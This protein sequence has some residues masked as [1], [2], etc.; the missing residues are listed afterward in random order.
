MS[1]DRIKLLHISTSLAT[2]GAQMMLYKLLSRMDRA[3][4][5]TKVVS[6]VDIGPIGEKIQA[7]G[8]P[9]Q[10][11]GMRRGSADPLAVLR[12]AR[13]IRQDPPDIIQTWMYHADLVGGLAAKLAGGIPVAW[14][15]RNSNLDPQSSSRMT[16]WT[17]KTCARLS[18]RLPARIVCCSEASRQ[19]HAQLGYAADKMV[20]IPNGFDLALFKPDA[21]ARRSVRQELSMPAESPLIGLVARFDPQKDHHN[22]V[23]AARIFH[24][25][26]PETHFLL[27]GDGISWDNPK[28]AGWIEAAGLGDCFHLLG[29][30]DD[31]AHLM[32]ALDIASTASHYGEGFPQVIGEAMACGVPCVVTDVG[33]SAIIVGETGIVVPAKDP[34]ALADGWSHLLLELSR[35]ERLQL[36]LA[37]RQRVIDTYS[38]ETIVRQYEDLYMSVARTNPRSSL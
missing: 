37:A 29:R 21:A 16:I 15:I 14:G 1:L 7:M 28:L 11:L 4:F 5:D 23:Q 31:I 6:L 13:W 32:P 34:Q 38:L 33:D 19:V 8:L 24:A 27:C 26:V 30:R 9:V 2:G 12:L 10:A 3:A 25:V 20:V 22:F 17:A 36:G 35:E 18:R